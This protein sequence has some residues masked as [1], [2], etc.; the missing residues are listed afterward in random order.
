MGSSDGAGAE[1]SRPA[2]GTRRA[3]GCA[4]GCA[5]AGALGAA[6]VLTLAGW[7]V[8]ATLMMFAP[9]VGCAA[10]AGMVIGGRGAAP[11]T[12]SQRALRGAAAAAVTLAAILA[13]RVSLAWIDMARLGAEA[14]E[15]GEDEMRSELVR[16]AADR[17]VAA[18]TLAEG[19][20]EY[21]E[22]LLKDADEQFDGM[23]EEETEAL[24][25]EM[26]AEVDQ[27]LAEAA[28]VLLLVRTLANIGLVGFVFSGVAAV[29]A[30]RIAAS[31]GR[32]EG[33]G[34]ESCGVGATV[35]ATISDLPTRSDPLR[36]R[37]EL[38]RD[39]LEGTAAAAR[40]LTGE[41]AESAQERRAA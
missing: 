7:A 28:P 21:P 10:G 35:P 30:W 39:P 24:R 20:E 9:L 23:S 11:G 26:R 27:G 2:G 14:R 36:L 1:A 34:G 41:G 40:S 22:W 4:A 31:S 3:A 16:R 32:E 13:S 5:A 29:T 37:M 6:A 25:A 15:I 17:A 38:P 19:F 12:G 18:G 33:C 8:G